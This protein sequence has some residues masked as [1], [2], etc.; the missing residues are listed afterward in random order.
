MNDV[1]TI[2]CVVYHVYFGVPP[3]LAYSTYTLH[4]HPRISLK[5][6]DSV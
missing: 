6:V 5:T 1:K 4:T 2:T 3:S